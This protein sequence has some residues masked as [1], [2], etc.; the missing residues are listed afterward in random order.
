V[1]G[2]EARA[3]GPP[4]GNGPVLVFGD[5][6]SPSADVAWLWINNQHWPGWGIRVVTGD[7]APPPAASWG[8]PPHAEPWTPPWGRRYFDADEL[9]SV[10]YVRVDAD[11]RLVL[12]EQPDAGLVVVGRRGVGPVEGFFDVSTTDWLLQY[13]SHPLVLARSAAVVRRVTCCVDG[14]DHATAALVAAAR[15]PALADAEVTLLSVDDGHVDTDAAIAHAL[16]LLDGHG[17]ATRCLATSGRA[18]QKVLEHVVEEAP[19]LLVLGT[20]GWTTWDRVR[21]GSTATRVVHHPVG[22]CLFA[23]AR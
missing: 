22:T 2:R 12:D 7:S 10:D 1:T 4:E 14:S 5:D 9:S 6:G 23:T 11:P 18:P 20:R 21:L 3:G 15:L 8:V 16:D 19:D 13:P 17:C